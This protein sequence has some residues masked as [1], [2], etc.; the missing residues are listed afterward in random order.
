MGELEK[1]A[2]EIT[3]G[4]SQLRMLQTAHELEEI[5][6]L[7][8]LKVCSAYEACPLRLCSQNKVWKN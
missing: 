3:L 4:T 7:I 8:R 1:I 2:D 6:R 5:A